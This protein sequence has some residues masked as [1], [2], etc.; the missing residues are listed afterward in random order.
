MTLYSLVLFAHV[1]AVLVPSNG[2]SPLRNGNQSI[3]MVKLSS[4]IVKRRRE[5][6]QSTI[7]SNHIEMN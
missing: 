3:N 2:A 1:T 7:A 5:P 4:Q 6:L